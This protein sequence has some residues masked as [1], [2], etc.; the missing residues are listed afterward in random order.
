MSKTVHFLPDNIKIEI[1]D[2]EN[3]LSAAARAGVYINAYCGGNGTCGKCKII[4]QEGQTAA[5]K[6]QFINEA[7]FSQGIRLACQ[8]Q[9]LTDVIIQVPA[10]IGKEGQAL[11]RQPKTTRAISSRAI[12]ELVGKKRIDPPVEKRFLKLNPPTLEDNLPDLQR[13]MRAITGSGPHAKE[14][15]YDHPE[16][17]QALPFI[18]RE[19][20]WEVTVILLRGKRE[21]E[22]DRIISV[23]PGDTTANFYGLA[24]DIGTT[25]IDGV[26]LNLNS[27]EILAES[28]VHN[29]QI[30]YGEDVISRI[31][32]SQRQGGL[33]RLQKR[34]IYSINEIIQSICR[35]MIISPS[36]ISYIMSAGNTV[37]SHLLMGI[38]PKFL[39]EAPY[40]PVCS[41]FPLTIAS[42]LGVMAHPSVRLFQYPAI[43]SYV[44]GDIVA[45]VHACQMHKS[46]LLTLL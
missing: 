45:G 46:A 6:S 40:V 24:L 27:G 14:P 41:Q 33:D 32:Y 16:M 22:P 8:C 13:L 31:V 10:E 17:L 42:D 36:D 28:S 25:T 4:V 44:G 20:D 30:S 35:D 19:A 3:I 11:K 38:D 15:T 2:K 29:A 43:A 21:R 39:R 5:Q 12:D 9:P 18:L 7:D 34:V 26:L 23:E 37:M 1:Q